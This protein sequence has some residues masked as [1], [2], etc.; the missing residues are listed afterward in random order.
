MWQN[1]TAAPS[2]L[3]DISKDGKLSYIELFFLNE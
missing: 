3:L 1:K 2:L